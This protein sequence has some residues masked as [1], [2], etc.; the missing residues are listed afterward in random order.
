MG[1]VRHIVPLATSASHSAWCIA[2]G[3][4]QRQ[5]VCADP[6]F[7][8][9]WYEQ[10]PK[11]GL[12]AARVC[13][14]LTYRSRES[15]GRKFGRKKQ[16]TKGFGTGSMRK[17]VKEATSNDDQGVGSLTP[18][19]SP[20]IP[21]SK[22][23]DNKADSGEAP[24]CLPTSTT[25][26]LSPSPS[27]TDFPP[28]PSSSTTTPK[29]T[30]STQQI[31]AK[32]PAQTE[33]IFSAQSYL[34]YQ[35]QKF[36]SR[37]DANCFIHITHKMDTHD[38]SRGRPAPSY[39][40][41]SCTRPASPAPSSCSSSSECDYCTSP[42]SPLDTY[43]DIDPEIDADPDMRAALGR[44]PPR[45]LV[46]GVSSDSLFVPSEQRLIAAHIPYANLVLLDS[47]DG[48][49]GFLLEFE[50]MNKHIV[51]FLRREEPELYAGEEAGE[52]EGFEI[53]KTSLFGE[54]EAEGDGDIPGGGD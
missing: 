30:P 41:C 43:I 21:A 32:E 50:A 24:K 48:H 40:A 38:I 13:A 2:W 5:A 7:R 54:A 33:P 23:L 3:E 10:Q 6:D 39:S 15:F 36:I 34:R 42:P 11:A 46:I 25:E 12:A 28:S 49:D 14:M 19:P 1:Y 16:I 44:L 9:G 26:I 51:E 53:R 20:P 17:V 18:P 31:S 47:I 37:F 45:A 35:G 27:P 29:P 52:L 8:D 4:A 22:E